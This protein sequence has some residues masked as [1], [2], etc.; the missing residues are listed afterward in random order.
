M[1]HNGRVT[2]RDIAQR[3]GVSAMTVSRVLNGSAS[4]VAISPETAK[5]VWEIAEE[6]G[7]RPNPSAQAIRTGRFN[8]V[9][10]VLSDQAWRSP[11]FPSLIP[12]IQRA[13]AGHR[14]RLVINQEPDERLTERRVVLNFLRES[15]VDGLLVNYHSQVPEVMQQL[16][17]KYHVPAVW[18]NVKQEADCIHPDDLGC[19]REA[20]ESLIAL[21]HRRIAFAAFKPL[22]WSGP[23]HYSFSDRRAGCRQAL[24]KEGLE[25]DVRLCERQVHRGE[26]LGLAREYLSLPDRPTAV[27]ANGEDHVIPLLLAAGQLGLRVP[28]DLSLVTIGHEFCTAA[29]LPVTTMML[30]WAQLGEEAAGMILAKIEAPEEALEPRTVPVSC[31]AGRSC[32]PAPM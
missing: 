19:G 13:L 5:R 16:V 10:L 23:R 30:P 21:G 31:M 4:P 29:G 22:W 9:G 25:L 12:G 1:S 14:M 7:Y 17:D 11:L 28:E 27:I 6:L 15:M 32:G 18:M 24:E 2:L 8:S 3:A 20:A 26:R